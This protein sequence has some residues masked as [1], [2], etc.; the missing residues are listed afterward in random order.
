VVRVSV[1]GDMLTKA[2]SLWGKNVITPLYYN[3]TNLVSLYLFGVILR[4]VSI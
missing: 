4:V 3:E 1:H 2:G